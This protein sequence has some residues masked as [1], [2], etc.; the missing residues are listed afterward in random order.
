M[1]AEFLTKNDKTTRKD[2]IALA[3]LIVISV[4]VGLMLVNLKPAFWVIREV[5]TT[6]LG[7]ILILFGVMWIPGLF[8]RLSENIKK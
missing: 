2:E 4:A 3:L 5:H 7:V 1:T 6:L 8:H